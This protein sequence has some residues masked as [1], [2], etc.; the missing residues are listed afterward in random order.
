MPHHVTARAV[1]SDMDGTLIDSLAVVEYLWGTFATEHG[2][3]VQEVLETAHGRRTEETVAKFSPQGTDAAAVALALETL[4]LEHTDGVIEVP[5]ATR[6]LGALEGSG[7]IAMVTS[8]TRDLATVRMMAAGVPVPTVAVYADEITHGKPHPEGYLTAAA[9]LGCDPREAIVL[10]DAEAGIEAGL[11]AGCQVIVVG[12]FESAVTQGLLRVPDLTTVTCT[13][14][15][16]DDGPLVTL[17]I[18]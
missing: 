14:T 13:V 17:T 2:L 3:D 7:A 4:G 6:F 11:A 12:G 10:E 16:D 5:G 15:Q 18:D 1:L 9:K 8:A